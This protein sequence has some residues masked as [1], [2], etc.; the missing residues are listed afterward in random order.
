M[1]WGKNVGHDNKI[2]GYTGQIIL[3]VGQW[4]V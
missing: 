3:T 1:F 4:M 2:K